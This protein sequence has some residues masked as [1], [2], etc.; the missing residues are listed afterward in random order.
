MP[1]VGS[2]SRL[3]R[4]GFALGQE[5]TVTPLQMALA[6][7]AI[8]NGGWLPEPCLVNR[9]ASEDW[10]ISADGPARA[11][12][13]DETLARRLTEMLEDVIV[14]G[15][16]EEA[17]IP[18]YRVA[19][20]TGTAQ[21]AV[22]GGFDDEHHVAWFAGF[23][24]LPDPR[25]VVVVALENPRNEFWGSTT[26]APVFARIAEAAAFHFDLPRHGDRDEIVRVAHRAAEDDQRGGGV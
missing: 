24:P 2:W 12:V 21:R 25:L 9:A 13:L 1:E 19:G 5:L 23:L 14:N 22:K 26:A 10:S 4:A 17:R 15:T 3:S 18:G 16:G 20:K 11:R 6:Y 8:A 7:A